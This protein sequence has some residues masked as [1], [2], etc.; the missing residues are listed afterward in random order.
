MMK[1]SLGSLNYI[2]AMGGKVKSYHRI[3]YLT[4]GLGRSVDLL[5]KHLKTS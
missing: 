5:G 3:Y 4:M 2:L 1:M